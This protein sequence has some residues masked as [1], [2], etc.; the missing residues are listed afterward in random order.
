MKKITLLL[1]LPFLMAKTVHAQNEHLKLS[2]DQPSA[3]STV[4]FTYNPDGTILAGKKKVEAAVYYMDFKDSPADDVVLTAD[5]NGVKGSLNIPSTAKAFFL[6]FA[7]GKIDDNNSQGYFYFIYENGKPVEGAYGAKALW[8]SSSLSAYSGIKSSNIPEAIKLYEKEFELYPQSKAEFS[9]NYIMALSTS[10]NDQYKAK[11]DALV[12]EMAKSGDEKQMQVAMSIFMRQQKK[13]Q[14][15][16]LASILKT[17]MLANLSVKGKK[18]A[19]IDQEKDL[20]KKELLIDD[21][22]KSFP[23]DLSAKLSMVDYWRGQTAKAYLNGG[24]LGD[25]ERVYAAINNKAT[26]AGFFNNFAYDNAKQ[27]KDLE[28]DARICKLALDLAQKDVDNPAPRPFKTPKDTKHYVE[29]VYG[30]YADSYAYILIKQGK[31]L[32]AYNYDQPVYEKNKGN[33]QIVETYVDILMGLNKYQEVLATIEIILK[34]GAATAKMDKDLKIAYVKTKGSDAGFDDY[35]AGFKNATDIKLRA[36]L[37]KEMMK[38]PAPGF[39]LKDLDGKTVSLA[40]MKGKVVIVDFWA[41]WCGPCK[42]SFPGMQMA[43]NK[44]KDNPNVKFVFIDTWEHAENYIDGVKDFIAQT[45][46][47]FHVL[48]DEKGE[49]GRQSKVVSAYGVNG[50]PTKFIIDGN[51]NIRFKHVGFAGS[52]K[53]IL[54]E[55]SAMIDIAMQTDVKTDNKAGEE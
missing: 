7:A 43:V 39:T 50:I 12:N 13:A 9:S 17:K 47:P 2:A 44:F 40:D 5:G 32:E 35:Y 18:A 14:V 19:A 55:V 26:L 36:S 8:C 29:G 45:K 31:Y 53:G 41:T 3:G 27:G 28:L 16:S 24:K 30:T 4:G 1:I 22:A 49:D 25:F 37:S 48:L 54:D 51:G 42:S 38:Q 6:S 34:R 46:Y 15:D 52:D 33:I 10:G 20:A 23:D 21:F 11:A